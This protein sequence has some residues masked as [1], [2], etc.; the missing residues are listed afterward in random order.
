M[1]KVP[2]VLFL[3]GNSE[4]GN[5]KSSNKILMKTS[6]SG[7]RVKLSCEQGESINI[8]RSVWGRYST[9]ICQK[10]KFHTPKGV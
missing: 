5:E 6:C 2:Y 4:P 9:T 3:D 8:V 7:S 10:G 1:I